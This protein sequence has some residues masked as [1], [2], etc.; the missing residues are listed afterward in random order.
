MPFAHITNKWKKIQSYSLP[1]RQCESIRFCTLKTDAF[2][3][4]LILS[5]AMF[6]NIIIQPKI[7][8]YFILSSIA[9]AIT[10]ASP[11]L[12]ALSAESCW[13]QDNQQ[14]Q[15]EK[16]SNN[17]NYSHPEFDILNS[18]FRNYIH[19]SIILLHILFSRTFCTNQRHI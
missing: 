12:V 5:V 2:E 7:I 6:T 3:V 17:K 16:K 9:I 18:S 8:L 13:V 15:R 11:S 4:I 14:Q 10:I 19:K 1:L